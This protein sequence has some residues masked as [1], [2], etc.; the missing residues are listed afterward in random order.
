MM[1]LQ[2]KLDAALRLLQEI[3]NSIAK[4]GNWDGYD[5][6]DVCKAVCDEHQEYLEAYIACNILGE[7]GQAK[8]LLQL[9]CVALK[10]FITLGGL[11]NVEANHL[12]YL[13]ALDAAGGQPQGAAQERCCYCLQ[14]VQWPAN[15][16]VAPA[17]MG[18]GL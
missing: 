9:A 14:P 1:D 17:D 4:H 2:T 3:D 10:G 12:P 15:S 13:R 18:G 7:H 11:D 6:G 5:P 8:E 16:V